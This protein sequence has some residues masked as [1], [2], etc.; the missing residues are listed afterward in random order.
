[1]SATLKIMSLNGP[2]MWKMNVS[3]LDD[4]EYLNYL[5]VNISKWKLERL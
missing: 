3:L 1:M 5:S 2:G 4:E